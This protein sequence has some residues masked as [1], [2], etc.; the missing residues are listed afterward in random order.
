MPLVYYMTSVYILIIV[1]IVYIYNS[2][3]TFSSKWPLVTIYFILPLL[4][5]SVIKSEKSH[6][7]SV[8][9]KFPKSRLKLTTIHC[10]SHGF[11]PWC[12]E[13]TKGICKSA[14]R[15]CVLVYAASIMSIAAYVWLYFAA[16]PTCSAL[17]N[18]Y[19]WSRDFN[20]PEFVTD[21]C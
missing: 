21:C 13:G 14:M 7:Y 19:I 16:G 8:R 9:A 1:D 15:W 17:H 5:L 11:I 20:T 6:C 18:D 12:H 10:K 4:E 2:R 3:L